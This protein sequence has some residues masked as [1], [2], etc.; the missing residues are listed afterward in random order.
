MDATAHKEHKCCHLA[1]S[2]MLCHARGRGP[3]E[4]AWPGSVAQRMLQGM[5]V[6]L[7]PFR[8]SHWMKIV[9]ASVVFSQHE[10]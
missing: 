9:L 8:H 3:E 6:S 5:Q 1:L 7:V 4:C 2:L 10:R